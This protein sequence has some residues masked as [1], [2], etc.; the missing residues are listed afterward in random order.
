MFGGIL[1]SGGKTN[2][3]WSW[4]GAWTLLCGTGSA[5]SQTPS[6]RADSQMTY[7]TVRDR[8]VMFGGAF[9]SGANT[10]QLWER[11]SSGWV[12]LCGAGTACSGP[13]GAYTHA[14]AFDANRGVSVMH[15]NDMQETWEWNGTSW[16]KRWSANGGVPVYGAEATYDEAS[17]R[18]VIAG[19]ESWAW[20]GDRWRKLCGSGTSCV[21]TTNAFVGLSGAYDPRYRGVVLHDGLGGNGVIDAGG[22]THRPFHVFEASFGSAGP[23]DTSLCLSSP[24][25]CP[26]EFIQVDW[27]AGGDGFDGGAAQPGAA[28]YAWYEG[29]WA[30]AGV[31]HAAPSSAPGQLQFFSSDPT[32]V[33]QLLTTRAQKL[34]F[35]VAPIAS[36]G[37]G[38][39]KLTSTAVEVTVG[40]RLP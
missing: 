30:Y 35:A 38:V 24:S 21:Q 7:D 15:D 3:T 28:L 6:A 33:A 39:G 16:S 5:C 34:Y 31:P 29:N 12:Q 32:V 1:G 18:V 8:L 4:D 22:G 20:E 17:G 19:Q 25:T 9:P 27:T 10:D 26:L 2:Q 13:T 14:M 23:P 37:F 36:A 40:Y 11:G